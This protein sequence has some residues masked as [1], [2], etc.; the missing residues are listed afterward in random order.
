MSIVCANALKKEY[1]VIGVDLADENNYWKIKGIN[2][3]IFPI[4]S[5]DPKVEKLFKKSKTKKNL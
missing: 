4:E 5:S 1:A 3:G 2:D